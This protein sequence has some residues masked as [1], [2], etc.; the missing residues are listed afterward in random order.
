MPTYDY[1]C[2]R[3]DLAFEA[4]HAI[5]A[6]APACPA[7][8]GTPDRRIISPPAAHGHMARGRELAVHSLG[9]DLTQGKHGRGCP[10][11]QKN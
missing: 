7:C 3:C 11:C 5:G 10:C 8:G 2:S 9:L 6:A 1:R 4:R